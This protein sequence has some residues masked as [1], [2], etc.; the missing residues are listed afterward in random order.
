MTIDLNT[1]SLT[2]VS[3]DEKEN[4]GKKVCRPLKGIKPAL[5][6]AAR[7]TANFAQRTSTARRS[8]YPLAYFPRKRRPGSAGRDDVDDE[9]ASDAE[10]IG[11]DSGS[12]N[13]T[14]ALTSW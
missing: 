12:F 4:R 6:R 13:C 2:N 10:V 1:I 14:R 3:P 5:H 7:I 11:R 9:A 8:F